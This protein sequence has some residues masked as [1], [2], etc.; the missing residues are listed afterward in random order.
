MFSLSQGMDITLFWGSLSSTAYV[1]PHS[2]MASPPTA[3]IRSV[4][5]TL[6]LRLAFSLAVFHHFSAVITFKG[7]IRHLG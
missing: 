3:P 4:L 5:V 6:H 1:L 2:C 7:V